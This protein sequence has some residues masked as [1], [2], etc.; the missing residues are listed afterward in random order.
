MAAEESDTAWHVNHLPESGG[1]PSDLSPQSAKTGR[2]FIGHGLVAFALVAGLA[3]IAGWDA[4]RALALGALAGAFGLAPD[5]DI[6]YAPVGLVGASGAVEIETAFWA[7]GNVVHR[8]ATHSVLVGGTAAVA[9]GLWAARGG[10][11]RTIAAAIGVGVVALGALGGLLTAFVLAAFVVAVLAIAHVGARH[12]FAPRYVGAAALAGLLSHPFGDLFTGAPPAFL[13][14]LDVT[15]V[16]RRLV[17]HPDPTMHLLAAFALELATMWAAAFVYLSVTDRR[18]TDHVSP[19]ATLGLGFAAAVVFLPP[20]SLDSPYQFTAAALGVGMISG[21]GVVPRRF[22]AF[23]WQDADRPRLPALD[24]A[25][26]A[27]V[28]VSTA[29]VAYGALYLLL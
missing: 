14:P 6:L 27:L 8:G 22:W 9:A 23:A 26:T 25:M 21:V 28:A 19:H 11:S 2:M 20:P 16:A 7:A 3:T 17:L 4:E 5:V 13:Y 12:G 1:R 24:A 15:L 29:L 10:G 18:P